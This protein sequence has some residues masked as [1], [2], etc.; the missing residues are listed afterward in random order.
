MRPTMMDRD[1]A[2]PGAGQVPASDSQ[3]LATLGTPGVDDGAAT[4]CLHAHEE[5]MRAGTADL[6]GLVGALHGKSSEGLGG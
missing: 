2:S 1:T 6:A 5:A 3:A 4:T